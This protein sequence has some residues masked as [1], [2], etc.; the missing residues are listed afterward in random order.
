[1]PWHALQCRVDGFLKRWLTHCHFQSI[2]QLLERVCE[3]IVSLDVVQLILRC[4]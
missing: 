1:M 2:G 4:Y 3:T